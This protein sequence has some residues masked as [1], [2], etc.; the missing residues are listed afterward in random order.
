VERLTVDFA[1]GASTAFS[2]PVRAVADVDLTLDP[3][4]VLAL[5]GES[6]SGK[7]VTLRALMRLLPERRA[8]IGGKII[9][10]GH[11]VLALTARALTAYRG[12][13]IAMIFQEPGLALDP[14]YRLGDQ[15]AEAVMR[16]DGVSR[17][18]ARARALDLFERVRIPSAAQRL[19][20]YPHE[21]SGGMR[22][23]AMIALALACRPK[24]LLADEPTTALDATVQIQVLLLLRELQREL[25][26]AVIFVTHD[27]GV[28]TEIADRISVM[29]AGRIVE[30]G[31][32]RDV[33]RA[34][35]H[36]YTAGLLAFR[37]GHAA[38]RDA[39]K[40]ARLPAIP[41]APPDM[42]NLPAGCAFA[43]RCPHARPV[44]VAGDPPD[45]TVG[46]DHRARCVLLSKTTAGS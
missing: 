45:V 40:G 34:A 35:A 25:G 7:S 15:I 12:R 1:G 28:A 37:S 19:D 5:L 41:G 31:S 29:Y 13:S 27:I 42:A 43:P 24:V 32:C 44:C 14:V 16:H 8:V 11:D 10:D 36:P 2:K 18:E 3:G 17:R 38:A 6:G 26:L 46:P 39:A 4:E 30:T 22:Q 21:M 20:N 23:R 9:V 33:I